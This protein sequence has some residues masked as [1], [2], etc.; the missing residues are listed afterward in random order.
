M[1][2]DEKYDYL[3]YV[4][5]LPEDSPW[6]DFIKEFY[7]EFY[8]DAISGKKQAGEELIIN[9]PEM[10]KEAR[11]NH[12]S[13]KTDM[14]F[15][16]KKDGNLRHL[17]EETVQFMEDMSDEN[18]WMLAWKVHGYEAAL[19]V[20]YNQ[21]DRDYAAGV[22]FETVLNRYYER[23]DRLRRVVLK[24]RKENGKKSK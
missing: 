5:Q 10:I 1:S 9:D 15:R 12:N 20:I 2:K 21:A 11:R 3:E 8:F 14:L 17:D 4:D 18:D 13:M 19:E 22:S 6:K 23:R 16:A 7:D 24:D